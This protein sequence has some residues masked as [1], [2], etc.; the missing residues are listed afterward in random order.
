VNQPGI[1]DI[2]AEWK[3]VFQNYTDGTK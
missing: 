1:L 2:V 3:K